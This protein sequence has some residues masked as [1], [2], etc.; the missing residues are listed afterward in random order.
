MVQIRLFDLRDVS[1]VQRLSAYGRALA[2]EPIAGEGLNPLR[3]AMRAYVSAGYDHT[4]ALI[5]RDTSNRDQDCFGLMTML[6]SH[7]Q[8]R[9]QFASLLYMAPAPHSDDQVNAW[10]EI[11]EVFVSIAIERG[12]HCIVT[13]AEESSL[14]AEALRRVG[15]SHLIH[16]DIM[17]LGALPL[18]MESEEVTG[19]RKQIERDDLLIHLLS[20]RVVPKLVQIAEG[21]ADLTRLT[22]RMDCGFVLMRNQEPIA[23]V[24]LRQGR[25][26]HVM[27]VLFR[28]EAED[29]V[30]PVI[31]YALAHLC[32]RT[33]RPVYCMIPSYQSW[34]LP[35][36]DKL[37]FT[38]VTSNSIMVRHTTARVRQPVWAVQASRANG[39]L[40]N[41][42]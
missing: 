30:E 1:T 36:L 11:T 16:Q 18:E 17:K 13:E 5:R 22:H 28:A 33:R 14:E 25:R 12:A 4:V 27:Q 38:H 23:N 6:P 7:G 41:T 26:G 19:L 21:N 39:K 42:K 37:G 40:I 10:T 15:F 3:E 8:D 29:M 9:P 24:S 31:T 2:Y 32:D 20:M 35:T 34:I